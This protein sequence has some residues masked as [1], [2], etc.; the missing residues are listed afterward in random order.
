M[1]LV[2]DKSRKIP[3]LMKVLRYE[4]SVDSVLRIRIS[5]EHFQIYERAN[6]ISWY[7]I[8]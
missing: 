4:N 8:L 1:I 6:E 3:T 7:E 5:W 2:Y